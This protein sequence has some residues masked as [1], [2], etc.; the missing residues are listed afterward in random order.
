M[1]ARPWRGAAAALILAAIGQAAAAA[2]LTRGALSPAG[3]AALC[4]LTASVALALGLPAIALSPSTPGARALGA[5]LGIGLAAGAGLLMFDVALAAAALALLILALQGAALWWGCRLLQRLTQ[6][7]L[8]GPAAALAF[9]AALLLFPAYGSALISGLPASWRPWAVARS[10]ELSPT[11]AL[12]GSVLEVDLLKSVFYNRF[13][14][15]QELPY[16]YPSPGRLLLING[17]AAAF[18]ALADAAGA[19]L[20]RRLP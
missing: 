12:P 10:L 11:L 16:S 20:G 15:S 13:P 14:L 3:A 19:L 8:S 4:L 6:R 2:W 7:G 5:G 17:A 18:L 9:A 1:A